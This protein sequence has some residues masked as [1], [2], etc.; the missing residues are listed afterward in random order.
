LEI[1]SS[2][3]VF[4]ISL[5]P[6]EN[7]KPHEEVMEPLVNSLADSI[8]TQGIVHDPVIVDE[9]KLVVLDGMHRLAALKLL[10]CR[11]APCCLVDYDNP[12]IRIGSWY[13]L[14]AIENP[15]SAAND[16]LR[17]KE[18]GYEE[19][20]IDVERARIYPRT[21]IFT[22]NGYRYNLQQ[23]SDEVDLTRIA[24][25]L[26]GELTRRGCHV[27]YQPESVAIQNLL[28]RSADLII[29]VP[30]F[31]KQQVREFGSRGLLLPHKVTRHVMP[32][33]PLRVDVPLSVLTAENI[34]QTEADQKLR[35]LLSARNIQRKPPGSI[36]DGRQYEEEL[37]VFAA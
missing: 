24:V 29:T 10:K 1:S 4:H 31:T 12:L 3:F 37:L 16:L 27:E 15:E 14:L 7:L 36:V 11:F 5:M 21:I 20:K 25:N 32:S 2:N 6:I 18:L 13:R 30:V 26:E 9:T 8:R 35:A 22:R 28:S 17:E 19:E 34:S 23:I 33:R